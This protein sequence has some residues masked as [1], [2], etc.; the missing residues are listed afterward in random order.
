M[1]TLA[2]FFGLFINIFF[3]SSAT[4]ALQSF[5]A[6]KQEGR[7]KVRR[8]LSRHPPQRQAGRFSV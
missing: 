5:D 1:T 4:S 8:R 2:M 6:K 7:Q 3:I